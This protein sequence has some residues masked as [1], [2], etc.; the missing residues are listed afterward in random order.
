MTD[1]P[2][3]VYSHLKLR[4]SKLILG[5]GFTNFAL[6]I[7]GAGGVCMLFLVRELSVMVM[8]ARVGLP[9]HD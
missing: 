8:A 9:R 6:I 7:R 3:N 5:G 1:H 2:H 4:Y